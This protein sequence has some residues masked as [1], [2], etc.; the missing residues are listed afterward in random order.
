MPGAM[1]SAM[2]RDHRKLLAFSLAG[3]LVVEV[4][5]LTAAFEKSEHYG[6][7]A[8]I[9]RAA[10]AV[11]TNIVEGAASG[12]RSGVPSLPRDCVWLVPRT[13]LSGSALAASGLSRRDR[14]RNARR[15]GPP[16]D[17]Y[18]GRTSKRAASDV[19]MCP[20]RSH[21]R[22]PPARRWTVA[23]GPRRVAPQPASEAGGLC[24][25]ECSGALLSLRRG[26]L[27]LAQDSS[28]KPQDPGFKTQDP[29]LKTQDSVPVP[30]PLR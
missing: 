21:R 13:G 22:G 7:R 3:D 2:P 18:T 1:S 12:Q 19:T 23:A 4:Y 16:G 25:G 10:V 15:Q 11:P 9:R 29:G 14:R 28:L 8:Q 6:L 17:G 30:L 20:R 27:S 5:G 26:R 24:A